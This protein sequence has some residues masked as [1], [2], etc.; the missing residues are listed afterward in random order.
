MGKWKIKG[1]ICKNRNIK[2]YHLSYKNQ[3]KRI[4]KPRIPDSAVDG[5]SE[6]KT[7]ARICFSTSMSGAFRAISFDYDNYWSRPFYVHIPENI[8]DAVKNKNVIK[9]SNKLVFDSEYTN[10]YWVREKIKMKCIGKA[11][12]KY[13]KQNFYSQ[14]RHT[15]KIKWIEKYENN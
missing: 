7:I 10:E 4:F 12:F 8:V 3:D 15:V 13:A 6:N 2:L 5:D 14:Y 1:K 11:C 9:P